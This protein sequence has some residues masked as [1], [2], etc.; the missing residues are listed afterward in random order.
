MTQDCVHAHKLDEARWSIE[1]E[2][3]GREPVVVEVGVLASQRADDLVDEVIR[4]LL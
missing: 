3:V 1:V 4:K 2:L